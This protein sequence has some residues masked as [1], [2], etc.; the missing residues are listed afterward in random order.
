MIA[1]GIPRF[2][3]HTSLYILRIY[4]SDNF[5]DIHNDGINPFMLSNRREMCSHERFFF[6]TWVLDVVVVYLHSSTIVTSL[7]VQSDVLS[8]EGGG[9]LKLVIPIKLQI[10]LLQQLHDLIATTKMIVVEWK[11]TTLFCYL[12][13]RPAPRWAQTDG[14]PHSCVVARPT[15]APDAKTWS[16]PT[17]TLFARQNSLYFCNRSGLTSCFVICLPESLMTPVCV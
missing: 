4:T 17:T 9:D 6:F 16:V 3:C 8:E 5:L 14:Q 7:H 12:W 2:D 1:T 13:G 11:L 15:T 10:I